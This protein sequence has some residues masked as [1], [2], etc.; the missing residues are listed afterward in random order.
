MSPTTLNKRRSAT[1]SSRRIEF[2]PSRRWAA[3]GAGWLATA[4]ALCAWCGLPAAVR[5]LLAALVLVTG[6][7]ALRR[8]VFMRGAR[9][10]RALEW[11]ADE[12]GTYLVSVGSSGRWL[13]AIPQDCRRY[14]AGLWLL[15]FETGEG[16]VGALVDARRQE[17][18]AI[19]CLAWQLFGRAGHSEGSAGRELPGS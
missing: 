17:P 19:R 2:I 10:L 13:P 3:A 9:G 11:P 12:A 15:R 16:R 6:G 7:A 4:V 8:Y 5:G 1:A 18:R 14:G